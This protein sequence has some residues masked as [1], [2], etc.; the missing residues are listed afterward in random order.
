MERIISTDKILKFEAQLRY[1][2]KRAN[3]I[4]KYVREATVSLKGKT[5]T[6]F[7]VRELQKKLLRYVAD[8]KITSGTILDIIRII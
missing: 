3:T 2:E 1:E 5:R 7:I 4:E 6:V 8:R